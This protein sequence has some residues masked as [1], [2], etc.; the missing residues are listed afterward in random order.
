MQAKTQVY[1]LLDFIKDKN[2]A[3]ISVSKN[4]IMGSSVVQLGYTTLFSLVSDF[5]VS[6]SVDYTQHFVC[7]TTRGVGEE[8]GLSKAVD[9]VNNKV[10][11]LAEKVVRISIEEYLLPVLLGNKGGILQNMRKEFPN[12]SIDVDK[13]ALTITISG[14]G[15][16]ETDENV[17][18]VAERFEEIIVDNKQFVKTMELPLGSNGSFIGKGGS[19]IKKL[20]ELSGAEFEMTPNG[21]SISGD[22]EETLNEGEKAVRTWIVEYEDKNSVEIVPVSS[23]SRAVF[24]ALLGKGGEKIRELENETK[25]RIDLTRSDSRGGRESPSEGEG[26]FDVAQEFVRIAGGKEEVA[27]CKKL[28]E[29]I[30]TETNER[31][32]KEIVERAEK[33]AVT[34]KG[35]GGVEKEEGKEKET[36]T[37]YLAADKDRDRDRD[38]DKDKDKDEDKD[39]GRQ[40]SSVPVGVRTADYTTATMSKAARKRKNKKTKKEGGVG[41]GGEGGEELLSMLL[42]EEEERP[43]PPPP[44]ASHPPGFTPSKSK[45]SKRAGAENEAKGSSLFGG[46]MLIDEE[47]KEGEDEGEQLKKDNPNPY[48][49]TRSGFKVRM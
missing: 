36:E 35:Q 11:E 42:V 32:E 16:S 41:G 26:E 27:R 46:A 33:T 6:V 38:K 29:E 49:K 9:A 2:F 7:L 39:N 30:I 34:R 12:V 13:G 5:G 40:F 8:N 48:F 43:P 19:S 44:T 15:G 24:G 22:S 45:S 47:E 31:V 25:A 14:M 21:V 3:K 20:A 28:V 37:D 1:S 18:L 17:R 23:N 4:L 10:K